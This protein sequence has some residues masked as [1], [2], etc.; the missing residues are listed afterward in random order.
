[1]PLAASFS[2][3]EVGNVC[4]ITRVDKDAVKTSS[5]SYPDLGTKKLGECG[6]S[7]PRPTTVALPG[8][9]V[10]GLGMH[11][12]AVGSRECCLQPE[13][14]SLLHERPPGME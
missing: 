9:H 6:T 2:Y 7:A 3:S 8:R 12:E 13:S 1:M 10:P 5:R 11:R 14:S 4:E